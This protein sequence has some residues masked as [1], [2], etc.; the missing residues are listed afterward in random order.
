MG[1]REEK[2]LTLRPVSTCRIPCRPTIRTMRAR[3]LKLHLDFSST[4]RLYKV[5]TDPFTSNHLHLLLALHPLLRNSVLLVPF[6]CLF[7]LSFT[8]YHHSRYTG[9]VLHM[10]RSI[11]VCPG[12]HNAIVCRFLSRLPSTFPLP[13]GSNAP[14]QTCTSLTRRSTFPLLSLH[15]LRHYG[16]LRPGTRRAS[17]SPPAI[18]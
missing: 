7:N 16:S 1:A 8:L 13:A 12:L 3:N 17:I 14:A 15:A 4:W 5:I 18:S 6:N 9:S 10:S 2:L 11:P